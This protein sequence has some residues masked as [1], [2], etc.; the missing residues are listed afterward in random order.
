MATPPPTPAPARSRPSLVRR[1]WSFIVFLLVV[2]ALGGA[3]FTYRELR[4]ERAAREAL[5]RKV[6]DFDPRFEKFKSAV[7][8]VNKQLSS[9]IF[10][11]IDL[12]AGGWQP[13]SGGFYVIDL[14]MVPQGDGVKITGKVINPT[15][16]THDAAQLS[17]R[18]GTH[19]GTFGLAHLPP[20]VAQTFDVLVAGVP[21]AEA[22][23]IFMALESSTISFASSTTRKKGGGDPVDMDK[24]LK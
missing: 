1:L 21:P 18:I 8:D 5:E 9:T 24:A 4:R 13:I 12:A 19:R 16:V 11:E 6:A 2:G 7:R 14:G 17:A 20:G 22:K 15:S 23:R 3:A 10:Q